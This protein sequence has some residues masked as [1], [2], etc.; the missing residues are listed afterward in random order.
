MNIKKLS[1]SVAFFYFWPIIKA[2]PI[3]QL[4]LIEDVSES[5]M[6]LEKKIKKSGS[7]GSANFNNLVKASRVSG[8]FATYA[9]MLTLSDKMGIIT[10]PRR[11]IQSR[12]YIAITEEIV[13]IMRLENTVHHWEFIRGKPILFYKLEEKIDKEKNRLVWD[14]QEVEVPKNQI[15]PA[16]ALVVFGDPAYFYFDVT[17]AYACYVKP[18]I[19]LPPLLLKKGTNAIKNSLHLLSIRHFFGPLQSMV[20]QE[21]KAYRLLVQPQ[22]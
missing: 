6:R 8:F 11:H 9:G 22:V 12:V 7:A 17:V 14:I 18:N 3:I 19:F 10:F 15:I 20:K 16:E 4:P 1:I 21:A 13:P 5:I 2:D